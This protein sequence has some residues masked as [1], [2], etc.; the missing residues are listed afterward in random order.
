MFLYRNKCPAQTS[1]R[2]FSQ[3]KFPTIE[4]FNYEEPFTPK[5]YTMPA[6]GQAIRRNLRRRFRNVTLDSEKRYRNA[7]PPNSLPIGNVPGKTPNPTQPK[8]ADAQMLKT[9]ERGHLVFRNC[10][11]LTRMVVS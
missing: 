4:W 7:S 2:K 1:R 10:W 3:G 5:L 8:T 11:I 9:A 6:R